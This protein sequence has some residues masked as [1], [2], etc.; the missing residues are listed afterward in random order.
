MPDDGVPGVMLDAPVAYDRGVVK[1]IVKHLNTSV[2]V[3]FSKDEK[4]CKFFFRPFKF[5]NDEEGAELVVALVT[6]VGLIKTYVNGVNYQPPFTF[7]NPKRFRMHCEPLL[8]PTHP[9]RFRTHL[10]LQLKT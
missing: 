4:V 6:T 2:S 1:A 9:K 8:S 7:S 5:N 3:R 10:A